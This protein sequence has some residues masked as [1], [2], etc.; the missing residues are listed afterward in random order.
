MTPLKLGQEFIPKLTPEKLVKQ[1]LVESV[2]RA[3]GGH[4]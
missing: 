3:Q 4:E 2:I 1:R